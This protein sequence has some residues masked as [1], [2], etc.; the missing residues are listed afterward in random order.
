ME[1]INGVIIGMIYKKKG[2]FN[3]IKFDG[4]SLKV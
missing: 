4:G 2:N 3:K 1:L